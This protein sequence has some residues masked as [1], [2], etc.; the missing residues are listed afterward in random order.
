MPDTEYKIDRIYEEATR[1]RDDVNYVLE[2]LEG[3]IKA[4]PDTTVTVDVG[5]ETLD[6]DW[7][8][9]AGPPCKIEDDSLKL[10]ASVLERR[11]MNVVNLLLALAAVDRD[12]TVVGADYHPASIPEKVKSLDAIE[13]L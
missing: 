3:A 8:P 13:T 11:G 4:R 5:T 2:M 7:P 1:L 10:A 9:C 6:K 12:K